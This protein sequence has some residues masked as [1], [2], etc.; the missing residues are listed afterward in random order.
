MRVI[1]LSSPVDA[2][3]WEPDAVVHK[4]MTPAEGAVHMS[5]EMKAHF[6]IDFDP[7]VLPN[8]EL[9][10]LDTFTPTSH[11][12][13]HVDAPAHYGTVTAYGEPR[14]IE[15]MPLEWF[16]RP[17]VVL[18]VRDQPVG[19]AVLE[20]ELARIGYQP[21]PLDIVILHTGASE[22]VGTQ[23]Y[24]TDFCGLDGPATDFLL[25]LGIRVI[26][27]DAFSLD[28]PFGDTIRR[29]QATGDRDVLWP[30][31]FAGRRR[32]YCQI[33]RLHNLEAV[34]SV[35]FRLSCFP[36]KLVNSGAGWTRAVAL[37]DD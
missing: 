8:G 29:Y 9:L 34:P 23:K 17:A 20:K 2:N 24:F 19:V 21:Q 30:A 12:G 15:Q 14:T 31:H 36:V 3:Q 22:Y 37:L 25:D 6:G 33:E 16:L 5:E 1:D 7:S 4:I 18:D 35:G 11:T 26:G 32:E 28:A 10:S 13:T 27:T